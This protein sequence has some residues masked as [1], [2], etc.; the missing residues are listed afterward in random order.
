M[1]AKLS[2][3]V[4]IVGQTASGKTALALELAQKY[5]GEIICADSRTIYKEMDIGTAKPSV[6]EQS[7]IKHYLLDVV[8]PDK[9]FNANNFKRLAS[10][11]V[12][13]IDSRGK[14]PF[15]VGGT[16]LYISSL[17]YDFNFNGESDNSLRDNCLIIGLQLDADELK[18]R[19]KKRVDL[20]IEQ[21]LEEEVRTLANKYGFDAPGMNGIC[22][23]QWREYLAGEQ[24]LDELRQKLYTVTWQYARRQ[25]TWFKRDNNIHWITSVDEATRLVQQ[26]L[27]Q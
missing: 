25:K 21:G 24:S 3:L 22:Y 20:M 11:A 15:L 7:L 23:R 27:I 12:K 6:Q 9:R 14:V 18:N 2:P 13:E 16:G 17:V 8:S 1:A 5:N 10:K 26:F 4:V 19:I